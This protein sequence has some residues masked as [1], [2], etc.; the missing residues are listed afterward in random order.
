[1]TSSRSARLSAPWVR[2]RPSRPSAS[3]R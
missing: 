1:L 2:S 3:W